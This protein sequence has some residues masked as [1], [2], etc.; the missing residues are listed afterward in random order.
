MI[1]NLTKPFDEH[2]KHCRFFNVLTWFYLIVMFLM[3]VLV[4]LSVVSS[5]PNNTDYYLTTLKV[6][7]A[8]IVS[9][10][11]M[12]LLNTMCVKIP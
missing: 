7:L 2:K 12:R 11:N 9:Y 8:A 6:F 10:Y 4:I 5:K 1:P 3:S